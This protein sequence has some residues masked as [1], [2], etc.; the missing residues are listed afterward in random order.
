MEEKQGRLRSTRIPVSIEAI[1]EF[2]GTRD[3]CNI[4]DIS[5]TG[6]R[7]EVKQ[8]LVPGDMIKV[9]FSILYDQKPYTIE[10]WCIVRNSSGNEVGVE[11]D[12]LSNENKKR[13]V[14]YVESL[15]LKH[16]K[17]RYEPF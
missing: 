9:V 6:M 1:Y 13:L 3:K 15:L 11:Y 5:E 2:R 14:A 8:I 12:E 4:V 17:S 16:G 7:L 10:A